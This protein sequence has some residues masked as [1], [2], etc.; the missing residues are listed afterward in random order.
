MKVITAI[1]ANDRVDAH[2]ERMSEGAL[3]RMVETARERWIPVGIEHDPRVPPIGRVRDAVLKT[4]TDGT[5]SVVG[6]IE[7]FEVGEPIPLAEPEKRVAFRRQSAP[8]IHVTFDR[9]FRDDASQQ[10]VQEIGAAL[11]NTPTFEIKK[12][13]EPL[14]ILTLAGGFVLGGIAAGFLKEIGSDAYRLLKEKIKLL[15]RR[16]PGTPDRLLIF[17]AEVQTGDR[18]VEVQVILSNPTDSEIDAFLADGLRELDAL[19]GTP[20]LLH[21]SVDRIVYTYKDA[22][23][24]LSFAVRQDAAPLWFTLPR[25]GT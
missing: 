7:F 6:T 18:F 17:R 14:S 12:A 3:S 2:G 21:P 22:R 25:S 16:D 15:F 8:G 13:A 19:L 11:R 4:E 5:L 10:L 20:G 24:D 9:T 23:L 1:L